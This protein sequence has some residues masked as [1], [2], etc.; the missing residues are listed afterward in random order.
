MRPGRISTTLAGS[1]NANSGEP[2]G[3]GFCSAAFGGVASAV[4][5]IR[6]DA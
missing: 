3:L 1:V 4:T 5:P 2:F 6:A